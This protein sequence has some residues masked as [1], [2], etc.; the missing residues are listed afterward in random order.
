MEESREIPRKRGGIVDVF[1]NW[2][3]RFGFFSASLEEKRDEE[4]EA[5]LFF[6]KIDRET[7]IV[8]FIFFS[9]F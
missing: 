5:V 1:V 4:E 3:V 8:L 7:S 2:P 9:R 6:L